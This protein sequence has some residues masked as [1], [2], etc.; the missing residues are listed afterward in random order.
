MLTAIPVFI[1]TF[2]VLITFHEYGHFWA[3]RRSGIR[4]IRFSIGFGKPLLRWHDKHGTEFV[5]AAIPLGGY[6]KMLDA[7]DCDLHEL[8]ESEQQPVA[9]LEEEEFTGKS[10]LARTFV[11]AAGP[12]ANLLLAVIV[13]WGVYLPGERGVAPVIA[14]VE[15]GSLA[16]QAGLEAGQEIVEIDGNSTLTRQALHLQLLKRLGETGIMTVGSRY[17]SSDLVYESELQLN[18][19][20]RGAAEPDPVNA[21]GITLFV[22]PMQ[23]SLSQVVTGGPADIAGLKKGDTLTAIDGVELNDFSELVR[24]VSERPGVEIEISYLRGTTP[25]VASLTPAAQVL[26]NG[27]TVGRIGI[28]AQRAPWPEHMIREFKHTPL[29][30]LQAGLS[31]TWELSLFSVNAVKKMLFGE[32][33]PKNMAG[34]ITI[35]QV[36]ND[37]AKVGWL[38]WLNL[39]ALLSISLGIMNLLPIPMLDGGH[40]LYFLVEALK[41][42]PVSERVQIIG[43]QFGLFILISVFVLVMFNDI[44]R[45]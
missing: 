18:E 26:D 35:A 42:S 11:V 34:P 1:I 25:S 8:A 28:G 38:P 37:S 5:V 14:A 40:L 19:W 4:V 41:G 31:R 15:I 43:Q 20:L 6:V 13:L 3:A 29:Q 12:L 39:L 30:A 2:G 22:P 17:S 45:L 10:L 32:M 36:A 23:L 33:S 27:N 9:K 7:R 44:A 21:L 16:E 24:Y